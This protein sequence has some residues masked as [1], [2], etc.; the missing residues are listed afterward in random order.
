MGLESKE[1]S[2]LLKVIPRKS[3]DVESVSNSS[4]EDTFTP[5]LIKTN[6]GN[7]PHSKC[8]GC[9]LHGKHIFGNTGLLMDRLHPSWAFNTLI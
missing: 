9:C 1:I 8:D 6:F 5:P 3:C 2:N 7:F 4:S